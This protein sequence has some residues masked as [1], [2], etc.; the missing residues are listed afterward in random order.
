LATS[1][2]IAISAGYGLLG[3]IAALTLIAANSYL[4]RVRKMVR[5]D[6]VFGRCRG[7]AGCARDGDVQSI[8]ICLVRQGR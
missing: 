8:G 7:W 1:A 3:I 2:I 6:P 4:R 5:P